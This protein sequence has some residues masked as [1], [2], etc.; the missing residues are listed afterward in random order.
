MQ[1]GHFLAICA[2][3]VFGLLYSEWRERPAL[4]WRFKPLAALAFILAGVG[5]GALQTP[6]GQI[7]L[8]GLVLCAVGDILLI[9]K[10]KNAFLAGMAAFAAGHGAYIAAF[11]TNGVDVSMAVALT[12]AL[13]A[14]FAA[15]FV[16]WLRRDLGAFFWPVVVYSFIIGAMVVA[17]VGHFAAR[18]SQASMQLAIAATGFA[19]SDISV[20]RDRFKSAGFANRLW[21]LPLYF[22][23][24]CL[25]AISV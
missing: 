13:F 5:A 2:L 14:A 1:P 25:F 3:A 8:L 6:F 10:G 20:A 18:P 9:P 22:G 11:V 23:S 19:L 16:Y 15:G 21:G 24:Q 17:S 7:I 12:A 4:R